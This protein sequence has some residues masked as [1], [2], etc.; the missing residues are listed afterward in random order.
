MAMMMDG[1]TAGG[2]AEELP[3]SLWSAQQHARNGLHH[4]PCDFERSSNSI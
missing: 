2:G 1:R 4:I 3:A